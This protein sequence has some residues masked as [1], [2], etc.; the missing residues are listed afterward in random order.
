MLMNVFQYYLLEAK[1]TLLIYKYDEMQIC[2]R[3]EDVIKDMK[4][5]HSHILGPIEYVALKW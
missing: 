5:H 2:V 3:R 4:Q 1:V